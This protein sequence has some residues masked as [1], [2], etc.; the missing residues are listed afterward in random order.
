M[1]GGRD[2]D[3]S[4]VQWQKRVQLA[5][6]GARREFVYQW[7]APRSPVA[8]LLLAPVLI[9]AALLAITLAPVMLVFA[10][11]KTISDE[12]SAWASYLGI[13]LAAALVVAAWLVWNE[14]VKEEPV[15]DAPAPPS[16]PAKAP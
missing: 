14:K 3:R 5:A 8:R 15:A 11:I 2:A 6:G 9:L 16:P 10:I 4:I 7:S 12:N 1:D 13:L